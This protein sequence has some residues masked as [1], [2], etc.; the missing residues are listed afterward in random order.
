[1]LET[2]VRIKITGESEASLPDSIDR[3][4]EIVGTKRWLLGGLKGHLKGGPKGSSEVLY[5]NNGWILDSGLPRSAGLEEHCLAISTLIAKRE[6]L[7]AEIAMEANVELSCVI[8][9]TSEPALNFSSDFIMQLAS[10]K[11]GLDIDLYI[12][13]EFEE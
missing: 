3:K 4:L 5:K 11:I 10:G 7:L 1:M 6:T 9:A 8:Y 13:P 2:I 12:D